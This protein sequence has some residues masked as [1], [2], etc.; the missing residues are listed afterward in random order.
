MTRLRWG[1]RWETFEHRDGLPLYGG[2]RPQTFPT[3]REALKR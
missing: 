2:L 3:R 1:I